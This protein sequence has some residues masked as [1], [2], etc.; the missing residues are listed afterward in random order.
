MSTTIQSHKTVQRGFTLLE[1]SIVIVILGLIAGGVMW[2]RELIRNSELASIISDREKYIS[3]FNNFKTQYLGVPGDI[4]NA[5]SFW[6]NN[7]GATATGTE[8]CDGNGDGRID[9]LAANSSDAYE[10][11]SAIKQL[12]NAKLITGNYSGRSVDAT[13]CKQVVGWNIPETKINGVGIT[14]LYYDVP[15]DYPTYGIFDGLY[16]HVMVVGR[17]RETPQVSTGS[18][19]PAFTPLEMSSIDLKIDDGKPGYGTVMSFENG[20]TYVAN[21]ATTAVAD[22]AVYDIART[23]QECSIIMKMGL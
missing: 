22:T 21:C 16:G 15:N 9:G 3:A 17:G 20:S 10:R 12:A 19:L 4:E 23:T 18:A 14:F 1:L 2:G 13:C 5:T 11:F 7:C 8:T 6:G